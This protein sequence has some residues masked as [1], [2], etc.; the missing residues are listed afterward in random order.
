MDYRGTC[1]EFSFYFYIY[2]FN[3]RLVEVSAIMLCTFVIFK[4]IYVY[5][6]FSSN[7]SFSYFSTSKVT[8]N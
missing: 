4:N 3:I 1:F 5:V 8:L 6:L 7:F 2:N